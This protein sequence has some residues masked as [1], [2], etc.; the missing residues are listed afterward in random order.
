VGIFFRDELGY[1]LI[2][3]V[4]REIQKNGFRKGFKLLLINLFPG[5]D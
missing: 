1:S 3:E 2:E 4:F 5:S